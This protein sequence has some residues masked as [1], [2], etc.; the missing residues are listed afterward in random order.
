MSPITNLIGATQ[1]CLDMITSRPF[2]SKMRLVGKKQIL[3]GGKKS[4]SRGGG[5][6]EKVH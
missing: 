2:G 6:G 5:M 4:S 3:R 1:K